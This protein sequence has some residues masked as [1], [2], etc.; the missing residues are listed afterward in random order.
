MLRSVK[1]IENYSCQAFDGDI[2]HVEDIY[3]DDE[4]WVIRYL[5]VNTGTWLA[6]KVLIS[7]MAIGEPIW[8]EQVL[9]ILLRRDQVESCPNI[10]TAKP[11]SR[12][13]EMKTLGHYGYPHYWG[14][15]GL[16]GAT[17]LPGAH[18]TNHPAKQ[19]A[20]A[21]GKNAKAGQR[22]EEDMHLR[23][24]NQVMSYHVHATDGDIGHVHGMLM[25]DE[26]WAIRYLVVNTSNWWPG[27]KVLIAP[28]WIKSINWVDEKIYIDLSRQELRDAPHYDA[29]AYPNR[30]QE[31][32][33]F[34]HHERRPYWAQPTENDIDTEASYQ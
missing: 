13:K 5:I 18:A 25:D 4:D 33:I 28:Q 10:D 14:E 23:S 20:Q 32:D 21:E 27:Q 29:D 16:W 6:H 8:Q 15:T 12:Q 17:T 3:F 7:P 1:V 31:A 26:T 30:G 24:C 2:G 9:S 19:G 22:H 11:V 34:K